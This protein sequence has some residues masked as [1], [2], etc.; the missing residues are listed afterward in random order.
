MKISRSINEKFGAGA[1]SL[2]YDEAAVEGMKAKSEE[3]AAQGNRVY[4][5]LA[6]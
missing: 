1:A 4:L 5:P 2:E 3:F 6:D